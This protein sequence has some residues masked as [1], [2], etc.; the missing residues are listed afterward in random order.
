[1]GCHERFPSRAVPGA[2]DGRGVRARR[3]RGTERAARRRGPAASAGLL[4]GR[5]LGGRDG[6]GAPLRVGRRAAGPLRPG[7]GRAGRGRPGAGA[8]RASADRPPLRSGRGLVAPRAGR[9]AGRGPGHRRGP[10]RGQRGVR[11]EVRPHLPG[12]RVRPGRR[13]V[14]GAAARAAGQRPRH[15]VGRGAARAGPDQPDPAAPAAGRGP[16]RG[17]QHDHHACSRHR[18]R[19]SGG[20]R[21][22]PAGPGIGRGPRRQRRGQHSRGKHRDR[23]RAHRR[24][25]PRPRHRPGR[26]P[27][28]TYRLTFGTGDYFG[29]FYAPSP[30]G[31]AP[32]GQPGAAFF[33]EVAV[34]FVVDGET[35][36]YHVPL[37][38]S[39]FGYSTYRGS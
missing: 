38:L 5:A 17:G 35:P 22:G 24:R 13:G 33:P 21:P 7:R 11:A 19:R 34:T 31:P 1:M 2:R 30:P 25:R 16:Q 37:L 3:A 9:G 20:R 36:H 27:A 12:L 8:G 6:V 10:G 28:G 18:A 29:V 26:L 32:A 14:A 15:R 39:P 4:L 23:P